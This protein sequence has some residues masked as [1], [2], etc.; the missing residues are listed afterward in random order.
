LICG[1][2]EIS[3]VR[4]GHGALLD[5]AVY[6]FRLWVHYVPRTAKV[7]KL[8]DPRLARMLGVPEGTE[9]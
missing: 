6:G 8:T 2:A 1:F 9:A 3:V 7:E 4:L 5:A